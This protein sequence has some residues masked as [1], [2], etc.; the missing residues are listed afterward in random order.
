MQ[1]FRPKLKSEVV[2]QFQEEEAEEAVTDWHNARRRVE[3]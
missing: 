2:F 3:R 1:K